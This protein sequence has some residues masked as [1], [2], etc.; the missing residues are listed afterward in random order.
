MQVPQVGQI[1]RHYKN[2]LMTG[3]YEIIGIGYDTEL[4]EKTIIYKPLYKDIFLSKKKAT[5]YVRLLR[6]F[7]EDVE[8][9]GEIIPRFS[10]VLQE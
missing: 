7:Q 1:Y 3:D 4:K 2:D 10:L 8:W 6:V 9:R 5:A